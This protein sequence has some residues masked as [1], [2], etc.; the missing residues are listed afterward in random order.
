MITVTA[1]QPD[2]DAYHN[3]SNQV[4]DLAKSKYNFTFQEDGA[5]STIVTAFYDS[6]LLFSHALNKTIDGNEEALD[7]PI[8]GT[9]IV[10]RMKGYHF[11]GITGDVYM[12]EN[13][14]RESDYSLL[15]M[16]PNTGKF[17]IVANF[18]HGKGLE[19]V[20]GKSIHWSGGRT[21]P[22]PDK[23]KCGFDNSKCPDNCKIHMNFVHVFFGK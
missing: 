21:T 1:K 17:E 19:Y 13:G 10:E 4:K 18:I 3:F 12:N 15:D 6:V 2:D 22:P 23:P 20:T 11:K 8:N 7:R 9:D 16:N 14:D 5:V